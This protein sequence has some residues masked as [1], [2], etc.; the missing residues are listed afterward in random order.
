LYVPVQPYPV[1]SSSHCIQCSD[2]IQLTEERDKERVEK[3]EQTL[4]HVS[5]PLLLIRGAP[6][7][8]VS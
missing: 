8:S 6:L 4:P 1:L 3:E 7:C 2:V 5:D